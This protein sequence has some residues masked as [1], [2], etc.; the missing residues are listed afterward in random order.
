[1]HGLSTLNRLLGKK[2]KEA[3]RSKTN[4]SKTAST[5]TSNLDTSSQYNKIM[6]IVN[7]APFEQTFRV[8][9]YLPKQQ[10]YVERIGAKTQLET[11]LANICESKHLTFDK[12]EFRHPSD[13][14]Q[15]F[16]NTKTIGE[17]GLNE[18]KLVLKTE[19]RFSNNFHRFHAD[20]VMKYKSN[21]PDSI[22]SEENSRNNYKK[23]S[24]YSSTTSLNSL[25]STGMNL[26]TK[27]QAPVA[28]ARKKR[29]APRP[30][31]Q[32]SIP[33]QEIYSSNLT[34][35]KEP[36]QSILPKKSFHVSSPQLFQSDK[37][38][39][40]IDTGNRLN[41]ITRPTSLFVASTTE[42]DSSGEGSSSLERRSRSPSESSEVQQIMRNRNGSGSY[43]RKKKLAPI[44]PNSKRLKPVPS[45]RTVQD[46]IDS[47]TP[48]INEAEEI[49]NSPKKALRTSDNNGN[50]ESST[51]NVSKTLLKSHYEPSDG[52]PSLD[53]V[54][55]S[56]GPISI[57]ISSAESS[58]EHVREDSKL[59]AA[60]SKVHIKHDQQMGPA[61]DSRR[62]TS[63]DEMTVNIYNVPKSIVEKQKKKGTSS[64]GVEMNREETEV[65]VK[66][67]VHERVVTT[68]VK[69]EQIIVMSE[70]FTTENSK[71]ADD[72]VRRNSSSSPDAHAN[73]SG[74]S[75]SQSP[76]WTYQLPAP[77]VFADKVSCLSPTDRHNGKFFSDIISNDCH[78]TT[79]ILS[80]TTTVIS[81]ETHI[82]PVIVDRKAIE[83]VFV[84]SSCDNES[85]KSTEIITSDLEDGYLGNKRPSNGTVK[86]DSPA[87]PAI[88]EPE[89]VTP[90]PKK[91]EKEVIIEDYKTS[92]LLITRSD[93]FHT[94]ELPRVGPYSPPKRST[95]FLS[96]Q[97]HEL[98]L[99]RAEKI[100][101]NTPYSR[102]KSS[103]ELS[104][105]DTPSLQ[106]L[107]IIKNILNSSRKNSSQD[108]VVPQ[109]PLKEEPE[110][111]NESPASLVERSE[112]V[113]QELKIVSKKLE[114]EFD[115][116]KKMSSANNN[117]TVEEGKAEEIAKP[118]EIE[119]AI[120]G[121]AT[122]SP[123]SSVESVKSENK[124]NATAAPAADVAA[125]KL[126]TETVQQ[127]S[128]QSQEAQ[129]PTEAQVMKRETSPASS[130]SIKVEL[131]KPAI[132]AEE[133]KRVVASEPP[134]PVVVAESKP[135][136]VVVAEP[137][138][139]K[140][141]GPPKINFGTWNERPRA[142]ITIADDSDCKR[143]GTLSPTP[144]GHLPAQQSNVA[145]KRHTIH[146]GAEK[147]QVQS[148][149]KPRVLGVELKKEPVVENFTK[150]S[151]KSSSTRATPPRPII[152][153]SD[154]NKSPTS[155]DF[156]FNNFISNAKKLS[157]IV[158]GFDQKPVVVVAEKKS[159]PPASTIE[160]KSQQQPPP[161]PI[162]PL[163]PSF[164]RSA[165]ES[166]TKN[167]RFTSPEE[168]DS[169]NFSQHSL[170]KTGYK[171]RILNEDQKKES[172]FGRVMEEMANKQNEMQRVQPAPVP[173]PPKPP[174]FIV[175]INNNK[176]YNTF[177]KS[178]SAN[179]ADPRNELLDAIKSFNRDALRRK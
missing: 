116:M 61:D 14:S 136:V 8:T 151:L 126:E 16:D 150:V 140:Y 71:S 94:F 58:L 93:S 60:V 26:T 23:T 147:I 70:N 78:E 77:P 64:G 50:L 53:T 119:P 74:R 169:V 161:P 157:P 155:P 68:S 124:V 141:T 174:A 76:V 98:S 167:V 9:V 145:N 159:P 164:L 125:V 29:A 34:V 82:Q 33:E 153:N 92:R 91:V 3:S 83:N 123:E 133:P 103:S 108:V 95:S 30:P 43:E 22:S 168:P 39:N 25:D 179:D 41:A 89:V 107:E 162:V 56:D 154:V 131:A 21:V 138:P 112:I 12:Y 4:L 10:L 142:T 44:P 110:P 73:E 122:K 117:V 54:S 65:E 48:T 79:T 132:V 18:L 27:P 109:A 11:L 137:K 96:M 45:P 99:N 55:T 1:M 175:N 2:N 105:C 130:E 42:I 86:V 102:R 144:N 67:T 87:T 31:S 75:R 166:T 160:R 84:K 118:A 121:I 128:Q 17:V 52:N 13:L 178:V 101:N 176:P 104:I 81:G 146:F 172:I 66:T 5:S 134:K 148:A 165:S 163:K 127:Q 120:I 63:D 69:R 47:K 171:E 114:H 106:S 35:F 149:V 115:D 28:P 40:N 139:W 113:K 111:E 36:P 7:N 97:R 37:N 32:N 6:P 158:H 62:S 143:S 57:H 156:A 129:Q 19:S 49:E 59:P 72:G 100:D 88:A 38:N 177:K 46:I 135:V 24:P 90:T 85:D 20:D 170:K 51:L 80:D 173:P 152:I 15:S